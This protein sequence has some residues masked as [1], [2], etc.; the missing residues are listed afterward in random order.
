[1][2]SFLSARAGHNYQ[3]HEQMA[4]RRVEWTSESNC[5]I[6]NPDVL[7]NFPPL[8]ALEL[9]PP[10]V[11][12]C[13]R[14]LS[15][16]LQK[17]VADHSKHLRKE[18]KLSDCRFWMHDLGR[19]QKYMDIFQEYMQAVHINNTHTPTI[20]HTAVRPGPSRIETG[21]HS[22]ALYQAFPTPII[23]KAENSNGSESGGG[24]RGQA[25]HTFYI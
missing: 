14:V 17:L 9:D 24:G 10:T 22:Q 12:S 16:T 18:I 11:F 5:I 19:F 25:V 21:H 7:P 2:D 23:R 4:D 8:Q 3:N 20:H 6:L 15:I 1:M 13:M